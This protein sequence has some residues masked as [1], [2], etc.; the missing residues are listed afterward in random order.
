MLQSSAL[1]GQI[2]SGNSRKFGGGNLTGDW[3][4][5]QIET[6]LARRRRGGQR[7]TKEEARSFCSS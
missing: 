7:Q 1:G 3:P 6:A 2:I 4:R 5:E